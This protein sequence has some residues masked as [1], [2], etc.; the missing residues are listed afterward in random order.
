M[1]ARAQERTMQISN[2][3]KNELLKI[4]SDRYGYDFSDYAEA[5]IKRRINRFAG[6]H[7]FDT[8]FDLRHYLINDKNLF[9]SFILEVT[10]NVTE[11][12]RDPS[13]FKSLTDKVFPALKTYAHRKIWHAG[14][15]TGEEVYSLAI[16][17]YENNL[18]KDT[19]IYA[20]DI[21]TKVVKHATEGIYNIKA[22]KEYS[23]NYV[24]AG[25]HASLSDYYI[26]DSDS[27]IMNKLLKKNMVFSTHN[28][29]GDTSFNEFQ[30]IICRNVLIY[31]NHELQEKVLQLFYESL[32]MFGFLALGSKESIVYSKLRDK[33]EVVDKD[34]KIFRKIA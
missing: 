20:T 24:K 25:G 8:Y 17:L 14:C 3:E 15:S 32:G 27:V 5:S 22:M 16:L 29:A 4:M 19:I 31:F 2:E 21:N 30:M 12:F 1:I 7:K 6:I 11:M 34:E 23:A 13:F 33:F 18:Y 10:V 9:A 28:L 26:A